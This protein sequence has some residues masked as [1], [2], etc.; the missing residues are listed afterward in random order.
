MRSTHPTRQ[1]PGAQAA[2]AVLLACA[3]V[4]S[5]VSS[6][7]AQM[8]PH[9]LQAH[10]PVAVPPPPPPPA[11]ATG[12]GQGQGGNA[13]PRQKN[14]EHA[15][16]TLQLGPAGRWWD[17]QKVAKAVGLKP[18]QRQRMDTVF[19]ANKTQLFNTYR[20]LKIEE[21]K[22]DSLQ[23]AE[24]PDEDKILA[25][26]D[27]VTALRGQLAKSSASLALQLRKELTPDQLQK[28]QDAK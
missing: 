19:N 8:Q 11:S 26:I 25:Q 4:L 24:S 20:T 3:V 16:S 5:A 9:P 21:S 15:Q 17:D 12:Q 18:E 28:L 14:A 22:L 6:A 1:H 7:S 2:R 23:R 10:P 13:N 27:K